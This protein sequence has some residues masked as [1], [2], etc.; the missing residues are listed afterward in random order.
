MKKAFPVRIRARITAFTAALILVLGGLLLQSHA[1]TRRWRSVLEYSYMRSLGELSA[2]LTNIAADLEKSRY[3]GTP[4]QMAHLSARVWK[5]SGSAKNALSTLP[6]GELHL[7]GAYRFLSQAG[8][9]AMA[10]SRK[11]GTGGTLTEEEEA[12]AAALTEYSAKL[13]DY[14]DALLTH[15]ELTG[16][17]PDLEGQGGEA[18][19]G[20]SESF[21]NLEETVTGYPTL[22]YDGPFSDHLLTQAPAMTQNAKPVTEKEALAVAASAARMRPEELT[23]QDDENSNMPSYVFSAPNLTV[24]VT[25]GGGYVSY[26]INSREI[27]AH[28]M[29]RDAVYQRAQQYL[30][31]RGL[32]G[33]RATYYE[34]ADGIFTINY[35]AIDGDVTLYTD[36]IKV[37]IAMDDG[38][39]AYFDARGYLSN[40]KERTFE[41][42]ALTPE[43]ALKSVSPHLRPGQR[44]LALIPTPGRGEVLTYE[45]QCTSADDPQQKV[46][47]YINAQTGTEEN[48]L[49]LVTTP[50]GTLTK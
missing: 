5:E 32:S 24:G 15:T 31:E 48:I 30:D 16:I 2:N 36:L 23:R 29:R 13:R 17:T 50:E 19:A 46:L 21:S 9:Y 44:R 4:I 26:L 40:H 18:P 45:F 27:G 49:I 3:V 42:P 12:S 25:K 14:V 33:V 37:G 6:M 41:P 7:D 1:E 38:S 11:V 10:L 22:I 43:D 20:F 35:A 8:D 39:V 28:R 47:V 34:L